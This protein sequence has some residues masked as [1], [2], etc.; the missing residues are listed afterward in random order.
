MVYHQLGTAF[1]LV[2]QYYAYVLL[3]NTFENLDHAPGPLHVI[4]QLS[5]FWYDETTTVTLA[6]EA[7]RVAGDNGRYIITPLH[8]VILYGDVYNTL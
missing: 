4:Q 8:V 6:N 1:A 3:E 7:L 2:T 5:Q